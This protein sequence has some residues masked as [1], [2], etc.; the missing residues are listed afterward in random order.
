MF[1]GLIGKKITVELKNDMSV[2]GILVGVDQYLN[3]KLSDAKPVDS[4][5]F[6]H[7]VLFLFC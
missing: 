6:P 1:S 5:R 3:I 7:M 4:K 2:E